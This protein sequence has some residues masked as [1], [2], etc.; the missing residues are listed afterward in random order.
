MCS[1]E[2]NTLDLS[3]N[4]SEDFFVLKKVVSSH[5]HQSI[6]QKGCVFLISYLSLAILHRECLVIAGIFVYSS[7]DET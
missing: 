3:S 2:S 4:V 6:M 1:S 7:Y 5:L